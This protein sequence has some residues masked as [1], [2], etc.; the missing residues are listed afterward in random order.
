MKGFTRCALNVVSMDTN[1]MHVQHGM[2]RIMCRGRRMRWER[3][4][5]RWHRIRV[6]VIMAT[7]EGMRGVQA[8]TARENRRRVD[9]CLEPRMILDREF[10]RAVGRDEIKEI[11]SGNVAKNL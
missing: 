4:E 5:L 11:V 1:K 6:M 3:N 8:T 7:N 2:I 10:R 9:Y